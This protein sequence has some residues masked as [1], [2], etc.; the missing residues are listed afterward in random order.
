MKYCALVRMH[1][2]L[3]IH[4][5]SPSSRATTRSSPTPTA[6]PPPA[7]CQRCRDPSPPSRSARCASTVAWTSRTKDAWQP[8][9]PSPPIYIYTYIIYVIRSLSESL[10]RRK[11]AGLGSRIRQKPD[12]LRG[13]LRAL[14]LRPHGLRAFGSRPG[15]LRTVVA[16]GRAR[17]SALSHR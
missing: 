9:A 5:L 2:Y 8:E 13:R 7:G 4:L 17:R 11:R 16:E 6:P 1:D 15:R 10:S 14:L 12:R 3:S